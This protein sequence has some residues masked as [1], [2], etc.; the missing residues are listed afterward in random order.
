M[1]DED[2]NDG[3]PDSWDQEA[4]EKFTQL[5]VR[6]CADYACRNWEHGHLLADDLLTYF[7]VNSSPEKNSWNQKGPAEK[8]SNP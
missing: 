6:Q 5:I 1:N 7:G 3:T 8:I 2:E 4:I